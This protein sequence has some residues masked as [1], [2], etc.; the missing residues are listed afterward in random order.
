MFLTSDEVE[1]LR[2]VTRT[3]D[4]PAKTLRIMAME[5]AEW[6]AR[7]SR[8]FQAKRPIDREDNRTQDST[9]PSGLTYDYGDS[10]E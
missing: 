6:Y 1:T 8:K 3:G 2:L 7:N 5:R 10:Q 4:S 9:Q